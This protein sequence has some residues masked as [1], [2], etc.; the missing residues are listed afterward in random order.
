MTFDAN[1]PLPGAPDPW[2]SSTMPEPRDGAPYAMTE[3]IAAE[4][5][6]ADRLANRL[7]AEPVVTQLAADLRRV[8]ES[9]GPIVI[10]GCGTS[11]H[12]AMVIAELLGAALRD[13]GTADPRVHSAQAF[14]LAG[15]PPTSG[16][17]LG[18][19]HEGGT[20]ATNEALR[21]AAGAG[22]ATA[23]ITVSGRSPAGALAS[24]VI[25]TG[26]QDQSWCHTVGY[27]S[28][29]V[30]G[31]ALATSIRGDALDAAA[32][33][34]V[35]DAADDAPGAEAIA[36]G[37]GTVRRMLIVGSG[38]DYPAARELALKIE[39]GVHLPS[40][41]HQLETIRHGHLAAAD[42]ATGLILVLTDAE[43]R[44]GAV[45]ER[46]SAVLRSAAALGMPAAA[47]LAADLGD[48]VP[49]PLT[50][51]GRVAVLVSGRLPRTLVGAL[52]TARP[53][54]LIAERLARARGMNPDAIGRDD[55]R[56]AAA[57]DA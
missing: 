15:R 46:A 56:Q 47:I 55:E 17:V 26:E 29:I 40:V 27:L 45:V 9:G 14:E 30:A 13:V 31:A 22:A 39:E 6:L 44:G 32:V 36:A 21:A 51:A 43:E 12:A 1:A 41:A 34:A 18:V 37:L 7:G 11:E 8:A 24:T 4:P 3:M 35:V 48:D 10:T 16:I 20:W 33:R 49:S 50:P 25:E 19:S 23:L 5:A 38:L 57:A 52:G 42:E 2:A 28:P 54:Q 53:L